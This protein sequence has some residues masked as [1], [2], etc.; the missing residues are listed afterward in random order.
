MNGRNDERAPD[1]MRLLE[2]PEQSYRLLILNL[3]LKFK[4]DML[5]RRGCPVVGTCIAAP[6]CDLSLAWF[7][8]NGGVRWVVVVL[9]IR[10]TP[11]DDPKDNPA[12]SKKVLGRFEPK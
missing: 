8:N 10:C 12:R 7:G 3:H 6:S 4:S 1:A 11:N 2:G 9:W 5:T